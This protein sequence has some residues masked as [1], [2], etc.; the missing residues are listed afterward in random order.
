MK[1]ALLISILSLGLFACQKNSNVPDQTASTG[2]TTA[3][4]AIDFTN[5]YA[6]YGN[7]PFD[8]YGYWHN[9]GLLYMKSLLAENNYN[10]HD[11]YVAAADFGRNTPDA[12]L[13]IPSENQVTSGTS[14]V[15][16][17]LSNHEA[18]V[19]NALPVS[20]TAK[21]YITDIFSSSALNRNLKSYDELKN[22]ITNIEDLVLA[23]RTLSPGDQKAV[24]QVASVTRHSALYWLNDFLDEQPGAPQPPVT[25]NPNGYR[26]PTEAEWNAYLLKRALSAIVD[27]IV[28]A[29]PGGPV[30]AIAASRA[31]MKIK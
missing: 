1:K 27:G 14:A 17:D 7:N 28:A 11:I 26:L 5:D 23:D 9:Y 22:N 16:A 19:I 30:A 21:A 18:N 6:A 31:V 10:L 15:L 4:K 12:Q 29:G 24:L 25:Q 13:T 20:T 2:N 3:N 8:A